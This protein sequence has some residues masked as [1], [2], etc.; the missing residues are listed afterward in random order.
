M[1]VLLVASVTSQL[2]ANAGPLIVQVLATPAEQ[3]LTGQFLAALVIARVPVFVFAAV[4]AVLLPGLAAL[5]G[6]G[7][8]RGFV[9][10]LGLATGLTA[11]I[12]L[13]GVVVVWF[14]GGALVELLFGDEFLVGRDVIWLIAV[15]GALFMLA[16]L[17]AQALLALGAE[18]WVVVGWCSGLVALVLA[19]FADGVVTRVAAMAL[20]AGS[21]V[22]LLVLAAALVLRTVRWRRT[23]SAPTEVLHA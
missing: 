15:S 13:I 14:W 7:D 22:A 4:Q 19:C 17:C 5:V 12:A 11:V 20:V 18:L 6:A 2:L 16:Q 10:R 9:R 3:A 8:A 23:V 21:G 1:A